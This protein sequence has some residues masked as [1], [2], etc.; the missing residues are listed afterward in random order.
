MKKNLFLTLA[1]S[2]ILAGC[3]SDGDDGGGVPGVPDYVKGVKL[4]TK[5]KDLEWANCNIGA[6]S[7]ED[8][9]GYY[10][11]GETT[12]KKTYSSDNY[13][14]CS[15]GVYWSIGSDISETKY[16]VANV[17]WGGNWRMPTKDEWQDLVDNCKWTW[18]NGGVFIY[19][20]KPTYE[21]WIFLPV[22]GVMSNKTSPV[23]IDNAGY[24]SSNKGLSLG[25]ASHLILHSTS[26]KVSVESGGPRYLGY[27]VRAV[28]GYR[29]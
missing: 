20:P 12:T 29:G 6:K 7:T 1:C 3:G 4:G 13:Q 25:D 23:D 16:D 15:N 19:G 24:W 14:Y 5:Y 11:W 9:G 22:N 8:V 10:A 2:L 26:K 17:E 28:R 18:V 27:N 21:N